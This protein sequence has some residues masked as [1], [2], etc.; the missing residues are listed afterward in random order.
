MQLQPLSR[1][2]D[3]LHEREG[4]P[5][6]RHGQPRYE[7]D[8]LHGVRPKERDSY[9]TDGSATDGSATDGVMAV[10]AADRNAG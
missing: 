4:L 10:V 3:Q 1:R 9:G 5:L 7:R 6:Y 2:A 8:Q